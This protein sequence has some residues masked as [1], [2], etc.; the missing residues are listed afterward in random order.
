MKRFGELVV[1]VFLAAGSAWAQAPAAGQTVPARVAVID[2]NRAV[3]ENAE[4]KKA[5]EQFMAEIGKKQADF[6]KIQKEIETI[7]NDLRT[8]SAALSD[9]AKAEMTKQIDDKQVTLTRM[10]EDAQR[11][12]P[13]LQQQLLGPVAERTQRIIKAYSDEAGLAVV[14]DISS[15]N[16]AIIQWSEVADITT[17]VIR[18][19]DADIAKNPPAA[20]PA[21]PATPPAAPAPTPR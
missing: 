7:Q 11:E 4:G 14:F 19:I 2:F 15:Q 10:N 18:R 8:K 16:S 20:A 21:R 6:E 17:E 13:Q 3:T 9:T 12:V 5:G 1:V